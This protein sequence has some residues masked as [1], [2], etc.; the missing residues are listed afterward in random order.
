MHSIRVELFCQC[1]LLLLLTGVVTGGV[2]IAL[3]D[4]IYYTGCPK[5]VTFRMLL[6]P[7]NPDQNLVKKLKK[8][9]DKILGP[10]D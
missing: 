7:K 4:G 2:A 8:K 6:K 1:G 10:R 5:K 9:L 3:S